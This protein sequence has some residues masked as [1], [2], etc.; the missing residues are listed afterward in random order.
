MG[1][2]ANTR[3]PSSRSSASSSAVMPVSCGLGLL[4]TATTRRPS[5]NS[6]DSVGSASA[7]GS[8]HL[9]NTCSGAPL[10]T[11]SRPSA[12]SIR[13]DIA[14]RRWSKGNVATRCT[15][16]AIRRPVS[17]PAHN[18]AS[19][20]SAQAVPESTPVANRPARSTESL[21]APAGSTASTSAMCPSVSV[22]VLSVNSTSMSP[23]SSMHTKRLTSTLTLA[24][25]RDPVARLVLTTAG[26][27]CGVIPTAIASANNTESITGR[28]SSR[29]VTRISTV[30]VIA[31]HSN[32]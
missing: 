26:N 5:A 28:R 32:R 9:A 17:A 21:C 10:T 19:I 29:L 23:R 12:S 14:R 18:A 31:T 8:A 27:N 24:S 16:T 6:R 3:K 4:A 1:S 2:S 13:R 11:S 20:A 15:G 25:R 7:G 30:S 22:P